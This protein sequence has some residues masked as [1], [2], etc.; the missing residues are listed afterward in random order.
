MD[1]NRHPGAAGGATRCRDRFAG[2]AQQYEHD[3]LSRLL[4]MLQLRAAA[5]LRLTASD[6]FLDVGC[7]T[8]AAVRD[9]SATV[10]LAVGV[11]RSA[12]MVRRAQE[13]A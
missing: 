1:H 8:G 6:R 10:R 13:L 2:W 12:A 11:D 7:A 5:R 4:T 9:A 3:V